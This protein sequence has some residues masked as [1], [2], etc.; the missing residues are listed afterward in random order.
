[1]N[2]AIASSFFMCRKCVVRMN[3]RSR[4]AL[5]F[6]HPRSTQIFHYSFENAVFCV[7]SVDSPAAF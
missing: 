3:Y 1:M 2:I 6:A 4:F 7:L 5:H